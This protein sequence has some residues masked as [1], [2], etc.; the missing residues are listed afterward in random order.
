MSQGDCVGN[1]REF[2][3]YLGRERRALKAKLLVTAG[4]GQRIR[5][6]GS[7]SALV[8]TEV[9]GCHTPALCPKFLTT[10]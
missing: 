3:I 5:G 2:V 4:S 1:R 6:G 7:Q 10:S 9:G 8:G